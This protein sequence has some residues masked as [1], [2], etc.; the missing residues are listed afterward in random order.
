MTLIITTKTIREILPGIKK[1]SWILKGE[2]VEA[3]K[4]QV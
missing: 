3:A 1:G 2:V 4:L